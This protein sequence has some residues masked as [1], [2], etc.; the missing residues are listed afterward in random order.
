MIVAKISICIQSF[1]FLSVN[2]SVKSCLISLLLITLHS[3]SSYYRF[4]MDRDKIIIRTSLIGV[5][6]NLFLAAFKS[7][8]GLLSGSVAIAMDAVNNL[9]DVLSSVITIA[10]TKLSARPAGSKHPFGYG[11]V[12]Y[13]T[14]IVISII[15]LIAGV[16]SLIESIMKIFNP[17]EPTYTTVTLVI[18]I[19]SIVVKIVLGLYVKCKGELLQSDALFDSVV[20][21]ATLVSAGIML[22]WQINIDGIFGTLISL[23]IVKAGI[24]MLGS[25]ISQLLGKGVPREIYEKLSSNILE[26]SEVHGVFDIILNYYGPNIIIGSLHINVLDTLS[27]REI[28]RL[29]RT[30]TED[31]LQKYG[32]IVT[33]G[34][35]AINT[36]GEQARYKR[37]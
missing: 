11:R 12:E 25:P 20:T 33:V 22:I 21:L 15:V 31:M 4:L 18:I 26:Y 37:R 6:A 19:V 30:V 32:I 7:A 14:A 2:Y 1:Y 10:G 17:T 16:V 9:S 29:T 28:H 13:F 27:A 23:V 8:V 36:Q 24:E 3:I 34:I 35:Y 5:L